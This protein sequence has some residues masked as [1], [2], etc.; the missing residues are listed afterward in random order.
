M[1]AS[2]FEKILLKF[3]L[4]VL[5]FANVG[6]VGRKK[7]LK[8]SM[9]VFPHKYDDKLLKLIRKYK[10]DGVFHIFSKYV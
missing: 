9:S 6:E 1:S 4:G 8:P 5:R 3:E 7:Y 2:T 10:Y